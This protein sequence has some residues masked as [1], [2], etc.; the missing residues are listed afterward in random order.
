MTRT[1]EVGLQEEIDLIQLQLQIYELE[2]AQYGDRMLRES[3][4]SPSTRSSRAILRNF[5]AQESDGSQKES[6]NKKKKIIAFGIGIL[7]LVGV[8]AAFLFL[9]NFMQ[10]NNVQFIQDDPGTDLITLKELALHNTPEDCWIAFYGDVYDMT[11]YARRHPGGASIVTDLAGMDGTLEYELFHP[12]ALLRSVEGDIVGTLST[13][14]GD[15]GWNG[16]GNIAG[17]S[18]NHNSG[19]GMA[20]P[21]IG[22]ANTPN[23]VTIEEL[24]RHNTVD[25][26]WVAMHGNVYDLTDYAEKHPGGSRIVTQLAGADGTIEY[27]RFH[28]VHLLDTIPD[29]MIGPYEAGIEAGGEIEGEQMMSSFSSD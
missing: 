16:G 10:N 5:T 13:A 17:G 15:S 29:T 9:R 27:N 19:G 12:E 1:V 8:I 28:S 22:C 18:S 26:C 25:D 14:A 6:S 4:L 11:N 3:S 7:L 24:K 20:T 2:E 23:C 21:E